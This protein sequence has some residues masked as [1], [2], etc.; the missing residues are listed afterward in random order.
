VGAAFGY[1]SSNDKKQEYRLVPFDPEE[2][3][4]FTWEREWRIQTNE[5]KL[6]KNKM[7]VIVPTA[8]EAFSIMERSIATPERKGCECGEGGT[9]DDWNEQKRWR[10]KTC[11]AVSLDLFGVKFNI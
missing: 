11:M 6:D 1:L 5:L 7:L 8:D 4:D 3:I 9:A 2:K 10:I